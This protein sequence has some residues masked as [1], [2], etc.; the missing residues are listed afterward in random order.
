PA[1]S[2]SDARGVAVGPTGRLFSGGSEYRGDLAQGDN[3]LLRALDERSSC[4][5]ATLAILPVQTPVGGWFEAVLT[6]VNGGTSA[7]NGTA[8]DIEINAGGGA[9]S[10]IGG[11]VPA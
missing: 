5:N 9:V 2:S 7:V 10:L 6:V 1:G 3:W 4:L 8:P 11:P